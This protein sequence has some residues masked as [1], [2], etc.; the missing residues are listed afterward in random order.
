VL[1][2]LFDAWIDGHNG[3]R[4]GDVMLLGVVAA[5]RAQAEDFYFPAP[6]RHA[7]GERDLADSGK[8]LVAM[9]KALLGAQR[10]VRG[11]ARPGRNAACPCGSGVKYKRC[12]GR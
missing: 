9:R 12:H 3:E 5:A 10:P 6:V 1:P 7:L 11:E 4:A 2:S 8:S